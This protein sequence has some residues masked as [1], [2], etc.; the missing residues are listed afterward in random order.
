[1]KVCLRR[2]YHHVFDDLVKYPPKNVSYSIPKMT[3][4]RGQ[5]GIV[6]TMKRKGW[7][8][9][10]NLFKKPNSLKVDCGPDVELIHSNSGFLVDN[11]IPWVIDLEH[12]AS[13]V[14]FESGRLE[15]VRDEI[16]KYLSSDHCKKI[17]PWTKASEISIRN[18]LNVRGFSDKIEVVY[19]AMMPLKIKKKKGDQMNFLFV[20]S[21][22]YG[23][24]GKEVLEACSVL[25]NK[26]DF[27]LNMVSDVPKEF[28]KKY[29]DFNFV[30][31]NLPRSE[32][33][34]KYFST[35][36]IFILP[37][38][39][40]TFGMVFLEAMSAGIPIVTSNNFAIPEIVGGSG[41]M[42]DAKKRTMFDE[43]ML[44]KKSWDEFNRGVRQDKPEIVGELVEK[45]SH[46]MENSSVRKRMSKRGISEVSGGKF[47]I[48][49][50][51]RKLNRIYEESLRR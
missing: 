37:S 28:Q 4:S 17:M 8:F 21:E 46:V 47:S 19:P 10:S 43:K 12:A 26:Y 3:S 1:M 9:Y 40:D 5:H 25:R 30:K 7:R 42:V 50:R 35:S 45:I 31:S 29:R 33:M 20:G 24:G 22:F 13:F 23:K 15:G 41:L 27:K 16:Q 36:N 44:F 6:N 34:R 48:R 49:E 18:S 2:G 11:K 51:N 39:I 14:G 38:Y 32:I